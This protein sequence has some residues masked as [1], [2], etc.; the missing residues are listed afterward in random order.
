MHD[1][2]TMLFILISVGC[3]WVYG[4]LSFE[5]ALHRLYVFNVSLVH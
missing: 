3:N 5:K 4:R 1:E 2:D